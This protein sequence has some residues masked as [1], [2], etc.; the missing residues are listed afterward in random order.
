[1]WPPTGAWWTY[2]GPHPKWKLT[3]PPPQT[4][5]WQWG[6]GSWVLPHPIPAISARILTASILCQSC[7]DSH[8]CKHNCFEFMIIAFLSY[9][10]DTVSLDLRI[11]PSPLPQC[12]PALGE[13][14]GSL[15]LSHLWLSVPQ[16]LILYTWTS[17]E[18]ENKT[19]LLKMPHFL[20]KEHRE[21]KQLPEVLP[22]WLVFIVVEV[23]M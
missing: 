16:T 8:S 3:R 20:V 4:I 22:Y 2:Q 5:N 1:M 18:L 11:F 14:V 10:E 7:A 17:C 13:G 9:L 23:A 21:I 19:L 12:S 15:W 6:G